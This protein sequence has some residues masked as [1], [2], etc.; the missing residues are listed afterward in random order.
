MEY[1]YSAMLLHSAGKKIDEASVKAILKATGVE[2]NE[3]RVKALV[4]SLE[5]VN[6]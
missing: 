6:I 1:V 5:G 2:A 4:A 3:S